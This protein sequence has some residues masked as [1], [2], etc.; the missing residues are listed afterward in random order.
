MNAYRTNTGGIINRGRTIT[1]KFDG[2][3]YKGYEGDTLASALLAN[4]VHMVA[5]SFKYHRPRGIVAAGSEDPAGLV[6]I[7]NHWMHEPN[8]RVTEQEIYHNMK[9]HPQNAWPS[10]KYDVG[11]VND[12]LSKFLSAGFYYKT[13][14]GPPFNWGFFEHFIRKSAGLGEAPKLKDKD[15]YEHRNTHC[16]VLIVGAGPSGLAAAAAYIGSDKRVIVCEETAQTGGQIYSRSE[17]YATIDGKSGFKWVADVTKQLRDAPNIEL[18]TRTC[19]TGYYGQNFLMAWEKVSDH[20]AESERDPRQPRHRLWR[21]RAEQVVLATGATER[22]LVFHQND[23]PGILLAGSAATYLHRYGVCVGDSPAF[24]VNNDDAWQSAFEH[25]EAGA[26]VVAIVDVRS[27]VDEVLTDRA[28]ELGINTYL[29]HVVVGTFGRDRVRSIQISPMD[30]DQKLS[31]KMEVIACDMLGISGGWTPNVALFAQSRGQLR[32]DESIGAFRPGTNWQN[33]ISVGAANGEMTLYEAL[34]SGSNAGGATAAS[35]ETS[36][37]ESI[38]VYPIWEIPSHVKQP[39]SFVDLQD[40]VKSS[41]LRIALAD[42][43]KSIEHAKR[44]TTT[45]MGTDQG[46]IA[47]MNAFGI[48]AKELGKTIPEVGTTTFRQP[49]KPVTFGAIAGPYV[50]ELMHPRRTT[51]MHMWH[52]ER[53]AIFETVGDWLRPR[54]YPVG[55]ESFEDAVQRETLAARTKIG[56]LDASTLGK[57]DFKG[58]DSREFLNRVYTN[59]WSKLGIGKCRYGLMLG[60]DGMVMDDGVTA[61]IADDHFHMTT[62]SGGAANVLRQLEDY[63]QTEWPDLEVYLTTTTEQWAVASVCGPKCDELVGGLIDEGYDISPENMPFMTW[64]DVTI[65]GVPARI[66]RISFTGEL[67]Y[68]INVPS[69][70]GHWLWT[71]LMDEGDSYG[72]TPYGTEAMHVLRAEKGFIIVGQETDGTMDP[73]DL[74]MDWIVSKKKPDFIGKRSLSRYDNLRNDRKHLVGLKTTDPIRVLQEGGQIIET[75]T[76]PE[77]KVPMLGHVT[78]SYMSPNANRSIALAV[79]KSGKT[80]LGDTVYVTDGPGRDPIPAIISEMDFLPAAK[81]DA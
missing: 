48:I 52:K 71:E 22:P 26:D 29:G 2:E 69:T 34:I 50:R 80:K 79:V 20:L 49:Y 78:S 5:R 13:F 17:D 28:K 3:K 45:G 38:A 76:V 8:T 65:Q 73:S 27:S 10:L 81:D 33:A 47:N 21:I 42:G 31:K 24:F 75:A 16:D 64:K 11:V 25:A 44:Y 70:Y 77:G 32:Y 35:L 18:V 9:A 68:E 39:K 61:C 53:G 19:V 15:R 46:K 12:K 40:D 54:A 62:T 74:Q 37:S 67:S 23:R 6:T 55:N 30:S 7:G 66:Y 72:I 1:F 14:M 56:I 43:F 51:P 63:L 41:D 58:K 4:G 59:A 57:I 36:T 60:E